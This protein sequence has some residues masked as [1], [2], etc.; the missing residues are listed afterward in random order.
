MI[1][2]EI[3]DAIHLVGN[4][5]DSDLFAMIW[6]GAQLHAIN[7]SG[8]SPAA[9]SLD[10]FK[11]KKIIPTWGWDP[12]TVPGAVAGWGSLSDKFGQLPFENVI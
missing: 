8:K 7:A 2:Q 12:V 1:C 4:S 11:G 5:L 9:L 3:L 10:K 6:D